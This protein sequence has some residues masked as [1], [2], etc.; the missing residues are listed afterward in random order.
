MG[1]TAWQDIAVGELSTGTRRITELACLVALEPTVLL[2]DEPAAGLAQR[3]VEALGVLLRRFRDDAGMT[4]IVIE[5]D[6]PLVMAI[7]DEVVAMGAGGSSRPAIR[8][9]CAR[10]PRSSRRTSATIPRRSNDPRSSAG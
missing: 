1:L 6:I 7:S 2:L 5:H 10:I 8:R 4:M 3:E 9:S